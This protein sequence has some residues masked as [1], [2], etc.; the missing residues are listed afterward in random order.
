MN[1]NTADIDPRRYLTQLLAN[2]SATPIGQ[3]DQGL[4]DIWKQR[5]SAISD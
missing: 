3:L 1:W 5:I 2:L 4:P